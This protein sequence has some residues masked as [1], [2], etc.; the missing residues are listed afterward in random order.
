MDKDKVGLQIKKQQAE[1]HALVRHHAATRRPLSQGRIWAMVATVLLIVIS[2]TWSLAGASDAVISGVVR[3]ARSGEALP[4][5]RI[6]VSGSGVQALSAESGRYMLRGLASGEHEVVVE[7]LGYQASQTRVQ[8][9]SGQ[10]AVHDVALLDAFGQGDRINYVGRRRSE[11]VSLTRERESVAVRR[12]LG[13]DQ[14]DRFGSYQDYTAGDALGR[15]AGVQLGRRGE[16]N[17]R[18]TGWLGG[19]TYQVLVDGQRLAGSGFGDRSVDAG[20]IPLD[21]VEQLEVVKT[22]TP[23]QFA[24]AIGGIVRITTKGTKGERRK[25]SLTGGGQFTPRYFDYTGA[26]SRASCTLPCH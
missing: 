7:Y 12:V 13:S 9:Q 19:G 22:L 1:S 21:Q 2:G 5:A 17:L 6:S 8:V 10:V 4:G 14:L 3:D 23:D 24:D 18:G 20:L 15:M 11:A 26:G 16:V 25:L